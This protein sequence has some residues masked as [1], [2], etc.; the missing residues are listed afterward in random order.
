MKS[1]YLWIPLIAIILQC[2]LCRHKP[3]HHLKQLD[4]NSFHLQSENLTYSSFHHERT[5]SLIRWDSIDTPGHFSVL[6]MHVDH[7]LESNWYI[8]ALY[9][10]YS[11]GWNRSAHYSHSGRRPYAC[12]IRFMGV[13]L[14]STLHE[15]SK[16]GSGFLTIAFSRPSGKVYYHGFDKNETNKIYCYYSTSQGFASDFAV[17]L[18]SLFAFIHKILIP[19]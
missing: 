17:R 13:G 2:S 1:R 6:S 12:T 9:N 15:Y 3:H 4:W 10:K 18:R 16:G 19:M 8:P 5:P 11:M 7:H 14:E